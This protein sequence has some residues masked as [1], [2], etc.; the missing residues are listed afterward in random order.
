MVST[1]IASWSE[2]TLGVVSVSWHLRSVVWLPTYSVL[3]SV[4]VRLQ[5]VYSAVVTCIVLGFSIRSRRS[6]FDHIIFHSLVEFFG[7]VI[8]LV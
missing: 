2:N 7:L 5:D 1:L 8:L 4:H 6:G 3:V